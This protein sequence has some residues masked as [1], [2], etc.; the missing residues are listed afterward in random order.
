MTITQKSFTPVPGS[1]SFTE[2]D[3]LLCW[4]TRLDLKA[5]KEQRQWRRQMVEK[6][7]K[8]QA[9]QSFA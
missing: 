1:A 6:M 5:M 9:F 4:M 2:G 3:V 8:L 7:W